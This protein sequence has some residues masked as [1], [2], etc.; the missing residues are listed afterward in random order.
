[1]AVRWID[2]LIC[3]ERKVH[4]KLIDEIKGQGVFLGE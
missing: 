3:D 4:Q 1:M 2:F